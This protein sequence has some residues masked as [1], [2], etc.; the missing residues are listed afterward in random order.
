LHQR[1]V[2]TYTLSAEQDHQRVRTASCTKKGDHLHPECRT[3]PSG[4][5]NRVLHQRK[6]ITYI[7]SA[8]QDHRGSEQGLAPKEGDHLHPECRTRP[9]EGQ[10]WVLPQ[11]KGITYILSAEQDHQRVRTGSWKRPRYLQT[12]KSLKPYGIYH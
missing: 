8:E 6:G 2:I 7:L 9:S 12:K 5:Q 3:R 1:K 10:N 11:R 4:G